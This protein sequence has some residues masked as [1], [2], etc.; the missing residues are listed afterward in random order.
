MISITTGKDKEEEKNKEGKGAADDKVE[1]DLPA[2]GRRR[3][4]EVA[5]GDDFDDET[6]N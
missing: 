3:T 1:E 4:R 6:T 5:S 2:K